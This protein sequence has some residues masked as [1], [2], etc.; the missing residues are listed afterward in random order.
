MEELGAETCPSE[1]SS[2]SAASDGRDENK[3]MMKMKM[4]ENIKASKP[5]SEAEKISEKPEA[6]S[7]LLFDLKFLTNKSSTVG[8]T[9]E[10]ELELN[11]FNSHHHVNSGSS[12]YKPNKEET[13]STEVQTRVFSCNF[14]KREFSTSQAL[15]G[16]QN[17]HKQ[18]RALAKR[19]QGI[20]VE[21]FGH[22]H[23]SPYYPYS[24]N[25]SPHYSFYGSFNRSSLG[26]RM[27]SMIH[28]PNSY[29]WAASAPSKYRFGH[30][31]RGAGDIGG[32]S[33]Q[34]LMLN[35][36]QRSIERLNLEGIRSRNNGVGGLG[37]PGESSSTSFGGTLSNFGGSSSTSTMTTSNVPI[38]RV[39]T[40]NNDFIRLNEPLKTDRS[41]APTG[42][43]LSLKL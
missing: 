21:A 9:S 8:G 24:T 42:L 36:T 13:K 39:S 16:H 27:D 29:S 4:K 34:P 40:N 19:R 25:I 15:G 35:S 2:I 38:N 11:L 31:L 3:K 18:E 6:S 14:C 5:V 22:H 17:A 12:L 32:W 1:A 33:R 26:V 7:R 30:D 20:D 43:D 23:F 28:K 37:R 41:S 10:S